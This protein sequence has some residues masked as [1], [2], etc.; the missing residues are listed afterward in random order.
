MRYNKN[1]KKRGTH[2][3]WTKDGFLSMP[4]NDFL[5]LGKK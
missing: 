3:V 5:D 4:A 2:Y 1:Q